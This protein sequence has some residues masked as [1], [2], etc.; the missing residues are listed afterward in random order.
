MDNSEKVVEH[1]GLRHDS[2]ENGHDYKA[3]PVNLAIPPRLRK[4]HDRDVTFH[5]YQH[6]ARIT[7]AEQDALPKATGKKNWL[8]YLIPNLQKAETG[9]ADVATRLDVNISD[10]EK[11]K[12]ISDDEWTNASRALRTAS[13]GA[14]FYLI[15]TDILGPFG[16]PYA[17]ATT[18]WG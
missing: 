9:P 17:F 3:E 1:E 2:N 12:L 8:A 7:R 18:G 11:R 5:E 14:I 4:L 16:L 13:T 15:T 6:Y 10:L